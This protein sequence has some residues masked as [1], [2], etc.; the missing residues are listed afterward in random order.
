MESDVKSEQA[1]ENFQNLKEIIDYCITY[2]PST[3]DALAHTLLADALFIRKPDQAI[4]HYQK[5][6]KIDSKYIDAYTGLIYIFGV[7]KRYEEAMA[8]FKKAIKL[9]PGNASL[10]QNWGVA[11]GNLKRYEEAIVQFKKAIDLNPEDANAYM[12]W[13]FALEKLNRHEEAKIQY[14]NAVKYKPEFLNII[15]AVRKKMLF[16]KSSISEES[17]ILFQKGKLPELNSNYQ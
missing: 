8:L 15:S 1:E 7:L 16:D 5:A 4:F 17:I 14:K 2:A 11:L 10:F 3:D 13:G 6:I 12:N 9:D